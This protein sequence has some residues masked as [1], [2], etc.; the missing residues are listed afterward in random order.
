MDDV[1]FP[2]NTDLPM[3]HLQIVNTERYARDFEI[4]TPTAVTVQRLTYNTIKRFMDVIRGGA[5]MGVSLSAT[6]I[7]LV[8]THVYATIREH[9]DV[10]EYPFSRA[11]RVAED[12]YQRIRKLVTNE[13]SPDFN[14][15]TADACG[16]PYTYITQVSEYQKTFHVSLNG[17]F[18]INKWIGELNSAIKLA[19]ADEPGAH[20][21]CWNIV[22]LSRPLVSAL[23]G[24]VCPE[25]NELRHIQL[26]EDIYCRWRNT[27]FNCSNLAPVNGSR[28]EPDTVMALYYASLDKAKTRTLHR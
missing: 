5:T 24:P 21:R 22:L 1:D 4:P 9:G 3:K 20:E 15:L 23:K 13:T 8:A 28:L 17:V 2:A 10:A 6:N 16:N 25:I 18:R 12:Y 19:V 27:V 26:Q 11:V 7:P 14:L